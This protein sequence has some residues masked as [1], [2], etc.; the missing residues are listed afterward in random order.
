MEH[1]QYQDIDNQPHRNGDTNFRIWQ[2]EDDDD[3]GA[4]SAEMSQIRSR[5]LSQGHLSEEGL[6][7]MHELQQELVKL[8]Q[9]SV[10]KRDL[11]LQEPNEQQDYIPVKV[12][13]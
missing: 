6:L 9:P 11:P 2:N 1:S 13:R 3:V 7:A 12:L 8:G 5:R 4:G 10:N